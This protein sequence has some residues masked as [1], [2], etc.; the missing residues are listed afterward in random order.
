MYFGRLKLLLMVAGIP[1][2]KNSYLQCDT[3][4]KISGKNNN[5][6]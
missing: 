3:G 5:Y 1:A 6:C 2:F 4:F